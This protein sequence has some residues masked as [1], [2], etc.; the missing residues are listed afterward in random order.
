MEGLMDNSQQYSPWMSQQQPQRPQP[1]QL[2]SHSPELAQRLPAQPATLMS[3]SDS[4]LEFY[5]EQGGCVN[6]K[7][8]FCLTERC[9]LIDQG[10]R[11]SNHSNSLLSTSCSCKDDNCFDP[12]LSANPHD[13]QVSENFSPVKEDFPSKAINRGSKI[14]SD[15]ENYQTVQLASSQSGVSI[16][17]HCSSSSSVPSQSMEIVKRIRDLELDLVTSQSTINC[18]VGQILHQTPR[19]SDDLHNGSH[20]S[21]EGIF[22]IVSSNSARSWLEDLSSNIDAYYED[23]STPISSDTHNSHEKD[24]GIY[25]F[26]DDD[27]YCDGNVNI[28]N[29]IT[30]AAIDRAE[31]GENSAHEREANC[32]RRTYARGGFRP[33][34]ERQSPGNNNRDKKRLRQQQPQQEPGAYREKFTYVPALKSAKRK[35]DAASCVP[36]TVVDTRKKR[37]KTPE[38]LAK[39]ETIF[40]SFGGSLITKEVRLE[41]AK[42][43]NLDPE[44]VRCWFKYKRSKRSTR[45][46]VGAD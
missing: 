33:G 35:R 7:Q 26:K 42:S 4:R 28:D 27:N 11:M 8:D 1:P 15:K 38:Q 6:S 18:S 25:D 9:K 10:S 19:N 3:F 39:L 44:E 23:D 36:E 31:G 22:S 14:N 45:K 41:I 5:N 40:N 16:M 21:D 46:R 17:S 30:S 12:L 34:N 2:E 13:H 24:E 20:D 37:K 29:R 43:L 32:S